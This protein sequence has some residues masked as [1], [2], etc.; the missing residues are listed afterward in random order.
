MGGIS[1]FSSPLKKNLD[2]P[3]SDDTNIYLW[4]PVEAQAEARPQAGAAKAR[5]F[6]YGRGET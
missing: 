6:D 1:G 4:V 5:Q 2:R 3:A